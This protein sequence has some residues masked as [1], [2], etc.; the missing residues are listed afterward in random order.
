MSSSG[1]ISGTPL[2]SGVYSI[3]VSVIDK[4]GSRYT[5][6]YPL[7]IKSIPLV[8]QTKS[9]SEIVSGKSYSQVIVVSGGIGP[10]R[11]SASGL[12]SGLSI[13]S[14]NGII[15]GTT[16]VSVNGNVSVGISVEDSRGNIV[17]TS[18]KVKV[19]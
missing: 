18:Y 17:S 14:T 19:K 3:I 15:S 5:G 4:E 13:N 12:P 16:R 7:E 6:T 1:I 11:Y 9:I 10:Y 2:V 8:I